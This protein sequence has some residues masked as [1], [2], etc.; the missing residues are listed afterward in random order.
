M[1]L[2]SST[3]LVA[4]SAA[5]VVFA[6]SIPQFATAQMTLPPMPDQQAEYIGFPGYLLPVDFNL[7][8]DGLF[9]IPSADASEPAE[10]NDL[11]IVSFRDDDENGF[12][13][14]LLSP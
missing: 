6:T 3:S 10:V 8:V 9:G 11:P 4:L 1:K 12:D 7:F 14:I 2:P 5:T 13:Q